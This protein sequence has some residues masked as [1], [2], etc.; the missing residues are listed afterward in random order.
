MVGESE[1][2]MALSHALFDQ[3]VFVHGVRPPTVP[4]GTGRLR[5]VPM[6]SHSDDDI[7]EALRA[8]AAVRR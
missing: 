2:T 1:P 5:V 3:G 7:S 4:A 6:A 8:F